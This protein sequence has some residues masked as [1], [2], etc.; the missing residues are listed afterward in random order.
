[1]H[2]LYIIARREFLQRVKQKSFWILL[3]LGP[4]FLMIVMIVPIGLAMKKEN[5]SEI[6]FL[7]ESGELEPYLYSD[8]KTAL[9]KVE[10]S[11]PEAYKQAKQG[12]YAGLLNISRDSLRWQ[13][14]FY[15]TGMQTQNSELLRLTLLQRIN[16]YELEN[17][18]NIDLPKVSFREASMA[19]LERGEA[20]A[21]AGF[22][23]GLF[24]AVLVLFFIN[25]YAH[26]VLRGVVE[27]KQNRISEL[28]LT[29]IKPV[30]FIT[31]KI[32]GIAS[33]AFLQ[34]AVW[35]GLAGLLTNT[36]YRSF[37]LE[38][39]SDQQLEQTLKNA[40]DIQQTMEMNSILNSVASL[41]YGF[42]LLGFVFYFVFGY[43]L[44]SALFAIVG[45][46]LG[47][48]SDAQQMAIPFTLPLAMPIILL[49]YIT[50]NQDS[51]LTKVL[52]VFPF[53]SPTTMLLRLPFGVPW[54]EMLLSGGV[55]IGSF[56]FAAYTAAKVY[57][58]GVFMYGKKLT[59]SEV[60]R[61]ARSS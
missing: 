47:N 10:G 44:Y 26:M 37:K 8:S 51:T 22:V 52:S 48:D 9:V 12:G 46:A 15:P 41:D 5:S 32:V 21:S 13:C 43:L 30:H 24:V 61:W 3:L 7:D 31:G 60:W 18:Q 4:F 17:K 45:I 27:E 39:F 55:L 19:E 53:T 54:W 23:A 14:R 11:V 56:A 59:L 50:E 35:L 2:P 20:D 38:R 42:L 57:R 1:M 36:V 40:T 33:V 28:I 16:E 34:M 29:S 58:L 6:L 49:Q 25:Q